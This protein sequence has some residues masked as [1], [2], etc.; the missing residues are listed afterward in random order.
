MAGALYFTASVAALGLCSEFS[1]K[2]APLETAI[3]TVH[4]SVA[5]RTD[6]KL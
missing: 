1:A 4:D 5:G 3:Y 6:Q 2:Q